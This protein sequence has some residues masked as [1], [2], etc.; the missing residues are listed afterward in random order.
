MTVATLTRKLTRL[1]ALGR[2]RSRQNEEV[3]ERLRDDPALLAELAGLVEWPVALLGRIDQRFMALP[4][5]VLVTAS[6]Q[7]VAQA[8][9]EFLQ[10]YHVLQAFVVGG[11][12]GIDLVFDVD[13]GDTSRLKL[14]HAAH[15]VQRITIPRASVSQHR[16]VYRTRYLLRHLDLFGQRQ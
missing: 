15:D 10:G 5:E 2:Q 9:D 16:Q 4:E 8:H 14:P 7:R 13:A 6:L 11:T 12:F 1:E 3:L